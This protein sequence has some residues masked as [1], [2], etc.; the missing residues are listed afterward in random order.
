MSDIKLTV[1]DT[2]PLVEG[3]LQ[4]QLQ[5]VCK[6]IKV[7][8]MRAATPYLCAL[9]VATAGHQGNLLGSDEQEIVLLIYVVVDMTTNTVV[10]IQQY[11]VKPTQVDQNENILSDQVTSDIGITEKMVKT[12]GIPLQDAIDKFDTYVKSLNIE[13]QAPM[14]RIVTDGQLPIRQCLH[15]E[16]S[17]KDIELPEYYNVF[18]DLRKDFSKFYNAPQDQTFNS[19]T[20]LVNYLEITHEIDSQFY[21][22]EVKDMVNIVQRLIADGHTFNSPEIVQLKLEPG[23]CWKN[24]EVDNNCVVRARGLPWQSSDQDIA[25]F[26][27]GLNIAKGG[28]ALCLSAHGRRNGEAVVRFVNQ[29]HRDMAMKRHKHHIGSRYIEVYKANGEDFINVAGGNSSEAQAFLTKG[30]QVIVRMRGLPYDC[31]AKDV[32][33]FFENGEQTCS[34]M[35]GEDG[36][37]FVKKPDGRATGDA[38]V[39]FA[40]E[41]DAPKALSKH[42]DLIGTRYIELFRSTTAEVQQVLNRAM[43]PSVRSTASDSNGNITTPV[44][45][46]AGVNN[47]PTA[48][49]G[50]VP[51]LPLPQHVITSG[52]RKDCIRLRGLPYEANVEH[53]LE[54]LGEHSKNI[55]FQGVHMVYNSVGHASGEAFIQMNN[56]GSA[57]QAAMAKHHNYMSFGKKQRRTTN[58][59]SSVST[60]NFK[61]L[62]VLRATTADRP[63]AAAVAGRALPAAYPLLAIPITTYIASA[64]TA[65]ATYH[66]GHATTD[67][68]PAARGHVQSHTLSVRVEHRL[69]ATE[70]SILHNERPMGMH[71]AAA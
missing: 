58:D 16:S 22:A 7:T 4:I 70:S 18:H 67:A 37:L 31:T 20:D 2:R 12:S 53:I 10:G 46:T 11:L 71:S 57:A 66:A 35:D 59:F 23:I 61:L 55:V 5:D 60:T 52:T 33:T 21:V 51:I 40:D 41:D 38:F 17:I 44:T 62:A 68:T 30:A 36:V 1:C 19:I 42:R 54:F 63:P 25:K 34:V 29:E 13:P 32:I 27:R 69:H 43:D 26:F 48:L 64:P 39:L 45:T 65:R 47:S 24:E 50:H 14:F 56:E 6:S 49:L 9:Y 15:R 28:V 8:N 3:D